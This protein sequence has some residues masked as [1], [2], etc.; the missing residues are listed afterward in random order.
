MGRRN[1]RSTLGA[2]TDMPANTLLMS[3]ILVYSDGKCDVLSMANK[4][5]VSLNDLLES[6][7]ILVK[8]GLL[9]EVV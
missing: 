3:H 5:G 7:D 9:E 2:Q 4:F 1:L 6:V 8:E